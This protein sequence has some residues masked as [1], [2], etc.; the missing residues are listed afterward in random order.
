MKKQILIV[1]DEK[2]ITG[3]LKYRIE[4]ELNFKTAAVNSG[5]EAVEL[6]RSSKPDLLI[7]DMMMPGISGL[8]VLK[9][10]SADESLKSIKVIILSAT[11]KYKE[12]AAQLGYKHYLVKPFKITEIIE[13]IN[14]LLCL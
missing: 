1:D 10:I 6:M 5:A 3:L 13:K 9:I 4:T 8:D 14:E 2:L 7:L 11:A 12:P